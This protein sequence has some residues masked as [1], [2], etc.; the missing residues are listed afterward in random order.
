MQKADQN[1]RKELQNIKLNELIYIK[2]LG[3]FY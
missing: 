2:T 3:F 1:K